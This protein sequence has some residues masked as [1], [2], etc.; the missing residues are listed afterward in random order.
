MKYALYSGCI[1]QTEQFAYELSAKAVLDELNIE[2]KELDNFSCC[3]APLKNINILIELYLAAR[4]LAICEKEGLNI[5]ALCPQC[6]LAFCEAKNRI[7]ENSEMKQ[8]INDL[9]KEFQTNK[10]HMAIVI[11][12]YGGTQGIITMEDILEEIVGE[13]TD[14]TDEVTPLFTKINDQNYIFEAKI[15][16]NDF[17]KVLELPDDIFDDIKGDAE[18][19]AGLILELKGEIP[20]KNYKLSYKYFVF[21]IEEV[22]R[23]RIKK[24]KVTIHKES[25]N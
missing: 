13:I 19:L 10:I 23:K 16:L 6:H 14:E 12:E 4:N 20:E 2:Y 18:T 25:E 17:Y 24:I 11:D 22:D 1:V 5:L 15:S 8:K 21:N 9:L 3:G 7:Q